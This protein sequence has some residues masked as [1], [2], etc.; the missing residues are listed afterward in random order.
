[1]DNVVETPNSIREE[2]DEEEELFDE[3]TPFV[4]E[5]DETPVG[6]DDEEAA[7]LDIGSDLQQTADN[8]ADGDQGLDWDMS[9]ILPSAPHDA[10]DNDDAAGPDGFDPTIGVSELA[11]E[12]LDDASLGFEA[13]ESLLVPD[14]GDW[15]G[16]EK[17]QVLFDDREL[18]LPDESNIK[19]AP[20]LWRGC[21]EQPGRFEA[22]AA[23]ERQLFVGGAELIVFDEGEL[24][25][26]PCPSGLTRICAFGGTPARVLGTTKR[27]VLLD[28]PAPHYAHPTLLDTAAASEQRDEGR[29]P[30]T[31]VTWPDSACAVLTG[32][33]RLLRLCSSNS[34]GGG[35]A[36]VEPLGP[37][38]PV[39]KLPLDTDR[40]L[41]LVQGERGLG[42][43]EAEGTRAC[44]WRMTPLEPRWA[45][46]LAEEPFEFAVQGPYIAFAGSRIGVVVLDTRV[47][48]YQR[49]PGCVAVAALAAGRQA[50]EPRFWAAL[51]HEI[52]GRTDL[53]QID[54]TTAT[55]IRI[56]STETVFDDEFAPARALAWAPKGR[57]LYV[58]GDF[59]V[60]GFRAQA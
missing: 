28:F 5:T 55:A 1:V 53:V 26:V 11:S 12:N 29:R 10:D 54:P 20:A 47:Q 59:G 14:L 44:A 51:N 34:A 46:S 31:I 49:V 2:L 48:S 7:D 19:D 8:I 57:I 41:V 22:L 40:P 50:G 27:G 18:E 4:V 58:A 23:T 38:H 15:R 6:L 32:A 3:G 33:G 36:R 56:A 21:F 30:P 37:E 16:D 35:S 43:S 17:E 45:K 24:R 9:G 60:R 42:L 25:A 13:M 52:S 39:V